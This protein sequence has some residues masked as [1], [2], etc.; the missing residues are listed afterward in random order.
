MIPSLRTSRALTPPSPIPSHGGTSIYFTDHTNA[1]IFCTCHD[2]IKGYKALPSCNLSRGNYR[3]NLI[4]DRNVF[5]E[6][7]HL[8]TFPICNRFSCFP[9]EQAR[10]KTASDRPGAGAAVRDT[11]T[12]LGRY[13]FRHSSTLLLRKF[14]PYSGTCSPSLPPRASSGGCHLPTTPP[15]V[16]A[17]WPAV[18][19]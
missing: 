17:D 7:S 8:G 18:G 10:K 5:I 13:S 1:V 4:E 6:S 12:P 2:M 16:P 9:P 15:P 11:R 14:F 3:A 19:A